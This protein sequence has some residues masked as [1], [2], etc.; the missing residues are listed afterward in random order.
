MRT[1]DATIVCLDMANYSVVLDSWQKGHEQDADAARMLNDQ[2]RGLVRQAVLT[3]GAVFG[4]VFVKG[5]GDGAILYFPGPEAADQFAEALHQ[6]S[7][8][9]HNQTARKER[10]E[11]QQRSFR[12]GISS[13]KIDRTPDDVAGF[14]VVKAARLEA[15]AKTGQILIDQQSWV[16]LSDKQQKAYGGVEVISGKDHDVR[17][18][19]SRRRQVVPPATWDRESIGLGPPSENLS[20]GDR[21]SEVV[22]PATWD[23]EYTGRGGPLSANEE[24]LLTNVFDALRTNPIVLLLAQDGNADRAVLEGIQERARI[25]RLGACQN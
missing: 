10:Q 20:F 21:R 25:Q 19:E 24:R 1:K 3:T 18:I 14:P 4:D 11:T 12:V 16:H 22:P 15:A 23:R 7:D 8:Q 6:F 17:T 5:T 9:Q 2:I 13:G